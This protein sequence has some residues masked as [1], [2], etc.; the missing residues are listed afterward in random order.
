MLNEIKNNLSANSPRVSLERLLS[1]TFTQ[2]PIKKM[3]CVKMNS[4]DLDTTSKSSEKLPSDKVKQQ[5]PRVEI[6]KLIS[7]TPNTSKS[8]INT[9]SLEHLYNVND[10][11]SS[12]YQTSGL[13]TKI[14]DNNNNE[15]CSDEKNET[16]SSDFIQSFIDDNGKRCLK[17]DNNQVPFLLT[18]ENIKNIPIILNSDLS[19]NNTSGN[20]QQFKIIFLNLLN[21]LKQTKKISNFL[22]K[23]Y[24]L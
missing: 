21:D 2:P 4:V 24:K 8:D 17:L 12:I 5:L 3:K 22:S 6:K 19:S 13:E 23:Y 16:H 20:F 10:D 7:S 9:E 15:D 14:T 18:D 11:I 1:D